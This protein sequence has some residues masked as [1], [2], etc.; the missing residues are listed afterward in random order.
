MALR[1]DFILDPSGERRTLGF[2][3]ANDTDEDRLI[4]LFDRI[5]ETGQLL[6]ATTQGETDGGLLSAADA[7]ATY[8]EL[9][10]LDIDSAPETHW[11]AVILSAVD[12]SHASG[13]DLICD[14]RFDQAGTIDDGAEEWVTGWSS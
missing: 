5:G 10:A 1:I 6:G 8:A 4:A 11:M 2:V 7:E 14:T 3:S 12:Q 9:A 13:L